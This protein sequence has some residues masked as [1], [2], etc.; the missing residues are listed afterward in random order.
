M[1]YEFVL[2]TKALGVF[3]RVIQSVVSALTITLLSIP[4]IAKEDNMSRRIKYSVLINGHCEKLIVAGQ[5][6]TSSC[7]P[8]LI[9]RSYTIGRG[10]F[11]VE[12]SNG[13]VSFSGARDEQPSLARYTLYLDKILLVGED[14]GT[15]ETQPIF[16]D[17]LGTC[18]IFGNFV[19]EVSTIR[20]TTKAADGTMAELEF[21][22][23]GTR[24]EITRFP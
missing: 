18:D 22:T 24:P 23:D 11:A 16:N 9:H 20:C 21:I 12:V 17:S 3:M 5:D 15:T 6:F 4:V 14:F 13:L 19:Q 7:K 10:S 8:I 1:Q 2:N